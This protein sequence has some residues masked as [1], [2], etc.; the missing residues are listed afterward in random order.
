MPLGF[1]NLGNT[2]Y[3]NACLQCIHR[4]PV[5][6]DA[7][8]AWK[9]SPAAAMALASPDGRLAASTIPRFCSCNNVGL[10]HVF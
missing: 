8:K 4:V 9:S 10:T 5:L 2:C 7:I 3:M 1:E 6:A